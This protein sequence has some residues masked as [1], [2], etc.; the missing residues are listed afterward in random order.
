VSASAPNLTDK[1]GPSVSAR[2]NVI[3]LER[4]DVA[5]TQLA[6]DGE[7]EQGEVADTAFDL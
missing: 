7:I 4:D 2:R 3:D 6:V 1:E 5:T